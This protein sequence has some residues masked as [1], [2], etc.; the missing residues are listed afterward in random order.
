MNAKFTPI[1]RPARVIQAGECMITAM[2]SGGKLPALPKGLPVPPVQP[3]T[4]IV[5]IAARQ[6]RKVKA[7]L[8]DS[9]DALIIE[10]VPVYD[11]RL[12]GLALLAQNV[13]LKQRLL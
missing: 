9:D 7:A 10:G 1:G 11:E 6:W 12:P 3:T 4:F 2:Q 5:Y 8:A 13:M